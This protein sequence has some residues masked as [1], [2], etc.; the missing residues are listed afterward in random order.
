M[1][2]DTTINMLDALE[3]GQVLDNVLEET[4][5]DAILSAAPPAKGYVALQFDNYVD[6]GLYF[7]PALASG[8][9]SLYVW[10]LEA[11]DIICDA[12]YTKAN[13]LRYLLCAANGSGKDAYCIA[14][15]AVW[16]AACKVRSRCIITSASHQQLTAQT[17]AYIRSL[18]YAVNDKLG[19]KF[20][21]VKKQHIVCTLTGSEIKLFA[22]DDPGKAEGYHPFPDFPSGCVA[23]VINEA[24]TVG[25]TIYAALTRCT[26]THFVCVSSPG[27]TAGFFYANSKTAVC[28]PDA[29]VPGRWYFRRVSA[30]DCPHISAEKV[31]AM[32]N[33]HGE[34]SPLYRSSILAEFTSIDQTVVITIELVRSRLLLPPAHGYNIRKE[35]GNVRAGADF[36]AG[37][38]E[39]VSYVVRGS[40]PLGCLTFVMRNNVEAA[41]ALVTFW[42]SF[43]HAGLTAPFVFGD[44]GGLGRVV[45]DILEASGWPINRVLNQSAPIWKLEYGNRGA[46]LWF[47]LARLLETN[48][49]VLPPDDARLHTQLSNRFYRQG[50]VNGKLVLESKAEARLHGHGS[51]D[52]A[53]AYALAYCGVTPEDFDGYAYT[54]VSTPQ[55]PVP[56]GLSIA[57]FLAAQ[58]EAKYGRLHTDLLPEGEPDLNK[59]R[60]SISG[61]DRILHSHKH[62][63]IIDI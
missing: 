36:A 43:R 37:G 48:L 17:E 7:H 19:G 55:E 4:D 15:F 31:T 14:L 40:Q 21:L 24:K 10:Q 13:A 56:K 1:T 47:M 57:D 45:I 26:Y 35:V 49:L 46:E 20:F 25:D 12:R 39:C 22:T 38:D 5:L 61:L 28:H 32:R 2:S 60:L 59:S 58:R 33:D 44:D 51:P 41:R 18:C 30:F 8:E 27:Q 23:I 3:R 42:E 6:F 54:D 11:A 34:N 53:D 29:P 62:G 52:R 9:V 63:S 50:R 16:F